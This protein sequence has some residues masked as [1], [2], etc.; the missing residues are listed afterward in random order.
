MKAHGSVTATS[1]A[2][3]FLPLSCVTN[4]CAAG[5]SSLDFWLQSNHGA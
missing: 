3:G 5:G 2:L 1:R 4:P